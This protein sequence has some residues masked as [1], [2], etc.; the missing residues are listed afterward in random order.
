MVSKEVVEEIY[1]AATNDLPKVQTDEGFIASA[2]D[3]DFGV[4]FSRDAAIDSLFTL[5]RFRQHREQPVIL[6]PVKASLVTMALT[7]GK[8]VNPWRDE[9]PGKV[10]HEYRHD[11]A[12]KNQQRLQ[13]L[14]VNFPVEEKGGLLFMLYYGSIDATPLFEWDASEF[15][16]LTGDQQFFEFL[17][18][19]LRA[20]FSW[21]RQ[22]L[23]YPKSNG[24]IAYQPMNEM[25]LI[26]QGW[27][28]SGNSILTPEGKH[29][30]EPIAL[31]EVQGYQYRALVLAAQLYK[32]RYPGFAQDLWEEAIALKERFNKDF[33]MED[34]GFFAYALDG[35]G[36]QIKEITSNVGH[37]LMSGIID[38][39][40][41][42]QVV[43]RLMQPDMLTPYGVRTLSVNSPNFSDEEPSAY[44]NGGGIW[45]HDNAIIYL[46]LKIRGFLKEAG[47]VR[48]S[49]LEAQYLLKKK[50]ALQ[51]LELYMV[52]RFNRLRLYKTAQQPQ[53][54]A[55][56]A[57][58]LWTDPL[59]IKALTAT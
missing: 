12:P 17:D 10:I 3:Q 23:H 9:E 25:A 1:D 32:K 58:V 4:F 15:L 5:E 52:D 29:P 57:N 50:Y 51:D 33:W 24:Y 28:D 2:K 18:P 42:S 22:K 30:E 31:V 20:A 46:G 14:K 44:H 27:K 19:H 47:S 13:E 53:S 7:Q 21:S 16:I 36:M 8:T 49:N 56:A 34:E 37:L 59:E 35:N 40:K 48:D 11:P 54:W 43:N 26:N 45:T 41:L 6:I 38:E 39:S 55:A